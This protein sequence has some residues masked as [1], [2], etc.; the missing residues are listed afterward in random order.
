MV[1]SGKTYLSNRGYAIE[2]KGNEK[3]V[4]ELMKSLTVTPRGM[5]LSNEE[6]TSFP[7]YK[8]NDKKMYLPKYYGLTKFGIPT[9]NQ[10]SDG[11]DCPNLIFKGVLRD[12]QKPAVNAF[13]DAVNDENKQGGLL[14][15]PCGFGKTICALYISTFYKKKTL[16]ICHTNFLIDQWIERI[17]QYIPT[18]NI[19]KIK[20]KL[21]EIEGKDIVIASL[22]SLAMREYDNN[23]F[24]KFGL[25]TLDE[26]FPYSQPILTNKGYI[27]I[28]E[29]YT[30]W[31]SGMHM[32][33]P[34]ILSYN[35]VT[36]KFE[37]KKLTYA[38]K[39]EYTNLLIK[40]TLKD[41][42]D[43]SF[44]S[45]QCTPDHLFHNATNKWT[46]A[47]YLL[48]G[49]RMTCC[50]KDMMV[51]SIEYIKSDDLIDDAHV[52]DIEVKDNHNF[53]CN[54]IVAHNCHHLGAEVFSRCLPIV[55]CKRMLG[56][57]ATLKRKDGLSKVFEWYIGKPV[58]TVKRKDSDV[59]I[60]VERYYDPRPAYCSEQTVWRGPKLGK[61]LNVAKMINQVCEYLPRNER[62]VQILKGILVKEPNR[63]VLVLSER[64]NHLQELENLLRLEGYTSIG[65]YVGGMN[66]EQ[67]D[68]GSQGD[69]ILATFQLASEAMDIPKLNT[70][71]LGSPV[72]SVEQPVGR[73]Q[74]KKKEERDYI[75][76][77]IDFIDEFS[78]F[79]RQG[80][81]R[82]AF[83][84]KNGYDIQDVGQ[85]IKQNMTK[86][87][88]YKFIIDEDE[89]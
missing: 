72:S 36:T 14:S 79:E 46:E 32:Q 52:Y 51:E 82:L 71:L 61:Q 73:I 54:Y 76:L 50:I 85:E 25:V 77:V 62:M 64:R 42:N 10:L 86:E 60:Q 6:A 49:D 57:S 88:K 38:W 68:K 74:R 34:L 45:I 48:V 75:P 30:L 12:I 80:A 31:K 19:G 29:L 59:I 41:L 1:L 3:L 2:K 83:Y 69:I 81:K 87:C 17:Q 37:W 67:L 47:R 66:K 44:H 56:L 24:K 63:K 9:V 11:E 13:L 23:L 20:Q 40:I 15:L 70:L 28:G 4:E 39:K 55:T 84:K 7:V 58:Y 43:G 78:L 33:I 22:Q 65:Y 53:I 18:A 27:P 5:Q 35:E 16:I 26:C 8:E 89:S 21:C